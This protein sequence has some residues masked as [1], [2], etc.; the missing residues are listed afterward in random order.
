MCVFAARCYPSALL[1]RA[2]TPFDAE[3]VA[4]ANREHDLQRILVLYDEDERLA[5]PAAQLCVEKGV[6]NVFVLT[7]GLLAFGGRFPDLLEGVPYPSLAAKFASAAGLPVAR[8][9]ASV[10]SLA[11]SRRDSMGGGETRSA[12]LSAPELTGRWRG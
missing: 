6:D 4:F 9:R 3:F 10:A 11:R 12:R 2:H 7:G 1:R 5:V 8:S